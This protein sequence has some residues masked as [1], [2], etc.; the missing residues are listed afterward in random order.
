MRNYFRFICETLKIV[1]GIP[2]RKTPDTI[3][4]VRWRNNMNDIPIA[5]T[6]SIRDAGFD[7]YWLQ[8]QI[9]EGT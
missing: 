2:L 4:N 8:E 9:Y 6:V 7:E 5:N 1:S 3:F